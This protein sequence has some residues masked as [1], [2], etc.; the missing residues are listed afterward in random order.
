MGGYVSNFTTFYPAKGESFK[1]LLY[2]ATP[3]N[4][5][6]LGDAHVNEITDQIV[7][8]CG[9]SGHNV[10]YVLRLANFMNHH[11]PDHND[12]HL[13]DLEQRI[14]EK[15]QLEQLCLIT[16]M[17]NGEGCITFI[18]QDRH[19]LSDNNNQAD[20]EERIESFEHTTR[21]PEKL[22]RCLNI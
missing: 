22:L 14:L 20:V 16:L 11:F 18:K 7:N 6:W 13:T 1:V 17:G 21:V 9:P 2:M 5:L 19:N 12:R 8:S 15:I 4:P 10:E 3:S